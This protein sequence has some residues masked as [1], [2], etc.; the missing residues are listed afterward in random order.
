MPQHQGD[1]SLRDQP[2]GARQACHEARTYGEGRFDKCVS[3]LSELVE[4]AKKETGKDA[5]L[6]GHSMGS[7]ISQLYIER[8][9]NI[10]G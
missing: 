9:H 2:D 8:F 3:N 4:I 10:K 5:F 1:R 7:F 6:L